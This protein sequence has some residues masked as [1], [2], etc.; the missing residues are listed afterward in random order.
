MQTKDNAHF[1]IV[2]VKG[3]IEKDG[4][5]LLAKRSL[6]ELHKPGVWSLPGGK[7]ESEKEEP[8]ILQKTLKK[9]IK[10]EVGVEIEDATSLM[11]DN[12]FIRVDDAHVVSLTFLCHCK[13][14]E[15]KPL[16]DTAEIKWLTLEELKRFNESEDFL[17]EEIKELVNYMKNK[18][19]F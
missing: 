9:E 5:F 17:R 11:Y 8:N 14:G 6:K 12:S 15:A 7:V 10:E 4:K 16:E 13:S 18:K 19:T 3:W 2:L 1:H